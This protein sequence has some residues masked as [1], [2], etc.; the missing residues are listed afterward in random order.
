MDSVEKNTEEAISRGL[1]EA[2]RGK[3]LKS[4]ASAMG[5]EYHELCKLLK[6]NPFFAKELQEYR[7]MALHAKADELMTLAD[8]EGDVQRLRLKSDNIKWVLSRLIRNVYGDNVEVR[9]V[10]ANLQEA[11]D[12]ARKRARIVNPPELSEPIDVSAD[13]LPSL[14]DILGC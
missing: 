6:N 14:S 2:A 9:V 11:L 5:M 7:E 4:I 3:S 10:N 1:R 12:A 8:E 13:S